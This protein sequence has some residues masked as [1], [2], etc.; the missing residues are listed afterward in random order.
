MGERRKR[1]RVL[2]VGLGMLSFKAFRR[3][4]TTDRDLNLL[5][6]H[7]ADALRSMTDTP[8]LLQAVQLTAGDNLVSHGLGRN[9]VSWWAANCDTNA[10]IKPV[11]VANGAPVDRSKFLGINAS[12]P[13]TLDLLVF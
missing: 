8:R 11:V 6:S 2:V 13:T 4:P 12:V 10:T 7:I 5:Q 9:Y 3:I 1:G